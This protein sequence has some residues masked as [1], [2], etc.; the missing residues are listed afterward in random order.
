MKLCVNQAVCCG[1]R[2]LYRTFLSCFFSFKIRSTL[3]ICWIY[4]FCRFISL[5]KTVKDFHTNICFCSLWLIVKS[6]AAPFKSSWLTVHS[7]RWRRGSFCLIL[8]FFF[9]SRPNK[10]H[11]IFKGDFQTFCNIGA[12]SGLVL[13]GEIV[14]FKLH[15]KIDWMKPDAVVIHVETLRNTWRGPLASR[16]YYFLL[17]APSPR[18]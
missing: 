7:N 11:W 2:L 10:I 13:R 16:I 18:L 3:N 4:F 1:G 5:L 15:R 12:L 14:S 6:V 9:L 17:S 8:F